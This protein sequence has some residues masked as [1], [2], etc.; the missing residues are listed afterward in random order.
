MEDPDPDRIP[1][2]A[3][4]G[5]CNATARPEGAESSG[6]ER[7]TAI[8]TVKRR[9]A[10]A[11]RPA[12]VV[13]RKEVGL[14]V[15]DAVGPTQAGLEA[16]LQDLR[17]IMVDDMDATNEA[18]AIFGRLLARLADRLEEI[19]GRLRAIDQRLDALGAPPATSPASSAEDRDAATPAR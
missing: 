15:H 9:L 11:A 6:P 4:A 1:I 18:T 5:V 3:H 8:A 10:S 14:A 2:I 16:E 13:F 7:G 17:R 19:D 12:R